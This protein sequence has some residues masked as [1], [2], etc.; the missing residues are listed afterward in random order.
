[1]PV[2]PL[3]L[4]LWNVTLL[5]P[6][7]VPEILTA[8]PVVVVTVFVPVTFTVPPPVAVKAVLPPVF[9]VS[10]P[11]KAIVAPVL[12]GQRNARARV[13]DRPRRT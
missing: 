2:P 9:S 10:P 8:I 3:R 12:L 11:V 1:M 13:G 6:I 5:P 7:V 4:M